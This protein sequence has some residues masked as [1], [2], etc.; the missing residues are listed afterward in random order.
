MSENNFKTRVLFATLRPAAK[1]A[2]AY[3][4]S[5]KD[6]R[7][8]LELAT[9][10]QARSRGLKM[11]EMSEQMDI[12]MSKVGLLSKQLKEHFVEPEEGL[13]RQVIA[14]LWAQPLSLSRLAQALEISPDRLETSLETLIQEGRIRR[15]DGRTDLFELTGSRQSMDIHAWL[16]RVDGLNTLFDNVTRAIRARFDHNDDHAMVR[17]LAFRLRKQDVQKLNKFYE[18]QLLPLILELDQA[19]ESEEDSLPMTM[20]VL[21]APDEEKI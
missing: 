15:I 3:G 9:Y 19:V 8:L 10:Q 12:S 2:Q 7:H 16:A 17:N 6:M 18:K 4:V 11:R 21:W 13:Y 5:L 20:T 1:L 14:L